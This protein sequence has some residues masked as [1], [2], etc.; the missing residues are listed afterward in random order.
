M[1]ILSLLVLALVG[2]LISAC[3]GDSGPDPK[4][5]AAKQAQ[6]QKAA[7]KPG[8]PPKAPPGMADELK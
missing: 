4:V 3:S 6:A 1:R 2:L 7:A 8:D 5:E